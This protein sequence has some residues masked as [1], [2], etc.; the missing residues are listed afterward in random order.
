MAVGVGRKPENRTSNQ[1]NPTPNPN[2]K[3]PDLKNPKGISGAM[4]ANLKLLWVNQ[5]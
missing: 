4:F 3:T 1:K 5:V 2:P